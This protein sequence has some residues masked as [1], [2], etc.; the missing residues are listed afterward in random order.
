MS[1]KNPIETD[2]QSDNSHRAAVAGEPP[3]TAGSAEGTVEDIPGLRAELDA[4]RS[5]ATENL[6]KFL[7]AKAEMENIRRR[8]ETDVANAHKY[9][10]ERFALEMLAVKDSLERARAVEVLTR[11]G[12][13]GGQQLIQKM[14]EGLDLTLKLMDTTFQ[15]FAVATVDPQKGEKFDPERHQAMSMVESADVPE[16]HV[17]ATVQRG[18][19]L[20]NRLL[21]PAMVVVARRSQS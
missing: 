9:G 13:A 17:L 1:Q 19:L 2:A 11:D 8:A 14:I 15:K 4:A 3:L 20:H 21:R 5:Q 10:I 18:Y 6:D 12:D 16:N 7:R